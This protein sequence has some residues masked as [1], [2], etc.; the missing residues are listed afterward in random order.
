LFEKTVAR[1]FD[2]FVLDGHD[3]DDLATIVAILAA[4]LVY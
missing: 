1:F 3:N 2:I 4:K